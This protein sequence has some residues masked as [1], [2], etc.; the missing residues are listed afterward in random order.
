MK[1]ICLCCCSLSRARA[2]RAR[3]HAHAEGAYAVI[4]RF[5]FFASGHADGSLRLWRCRYNGSLD[6]LGRLEGPADHEVYKIENCK[7]EAKTST[8]AVLYFDVNGNR[9]QTWVWDVSTGQFVDM[10]DSHTMFP[11]GMSN[12]G[13]GRMLLAG[14]AGPHVEGRLCVWNTSVLP[15]RPGRLV[16]HAVVIDD[17]PPLGVPRG[18]PIC[19]AVL[20]GFRAGQSVRTVAV[21]GSRG[22]LQLWGWDPAANNA[23]GDFV[24]LENHHATVQRPNR[25][26]AARGRLHDIRSI[27]GAPACSSLPAMACVCLSSALFFKFCPLP[28]V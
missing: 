21:G 26:T 24:L 22:Y 25:L 13:G 27:A 9:P 28:K 20:P 17:D 3:S 12:L 10:I 2:R 14:T 19:A 4:V 16:A 23:V 7:N 11:Y 5:D 6:F 18:H 15:D 8:V 1:V